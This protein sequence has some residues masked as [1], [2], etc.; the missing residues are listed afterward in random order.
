MS[1]PDDDTLVLDTVERFADTFFAP[2]QSVFPVEFG[3]ATHVGKVR[4]R[5]ED[6]FAVVRFRRDCEI[7][8]ASLAPNALAVPQIWSH[9]GEQP[10]W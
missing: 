1:N 2:P 3:A 6:H 5:N 9:P 10:G 4:A 8:L 7:M